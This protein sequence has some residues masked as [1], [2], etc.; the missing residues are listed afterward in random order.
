MRRVINTNYISFNPNN[1]ANSSTP[2]H[3]RTYQDKISYNLG[4]RNY[5]NIKYNNFINNKKNNN[6]GMENY[7]KIKIYQIR[8][9][10]LI[11]C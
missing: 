10:L 8:R 3:L 6:I 9:I 1:R 11:I 7:F 4:P 5:M 2:D